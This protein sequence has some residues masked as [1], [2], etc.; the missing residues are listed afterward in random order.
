MTR[1]AKALQA[2]RRILGLSDSAGGR[3]VFEAY[4]RLCRKV[5]SDR[6]RKMIKLT[7][8]FETLLYRP[9]ASRSPR[10]TAPR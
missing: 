4:T 1:H 10:R 8:A 5:E 7:R 6:L 9:P 2:S 3:D